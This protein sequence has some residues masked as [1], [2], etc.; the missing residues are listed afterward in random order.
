MPTA[1]TATTVLAAAARYKVTF[2]Y[3]AENE[4]ELSLVKGEIIEVTD[5]NLPDAGWWAGKIVDTDGK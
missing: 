4:D 1:T 5:K 2:D 3:T